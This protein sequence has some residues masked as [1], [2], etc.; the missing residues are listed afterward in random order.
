MKNIFEG[1]LFNKKEKE[2]P[3]PWYKQYEI[4]GVPAKLE[5][6]N[7][8]IFSFMEASALK[9]QKKVAYDF[10][11]YLTTYGELLDEI[12][13]C[14]KALKA[15]G[16]EEGDYVT[17]SMPNTPE[18]IIMFYAVN[19]VGAISNMIH[20]LAAPGEIKH[21]LSLVP[22]KFALIIDFNFETFNKIKKD[23]KLEKIITC[24]PSVSMP[25]LV[26]FG[27]WLTAGRKVPPIPQSDDVYDWYD[28]ISLSKNFEE[29]Y[30]CPRK[31]DDTAV[32]LYSGGTTGTSKGIELTNL[33]FN[34]IAMQSN[35][36]IDTTPGDSILGILPLFHCFGLAVCTHFVLS[37][38]VKTVLIPKFTPE[39]FGDLIKKKK[40]TFIVGVPALFEAMI[41]NPKLKNADLSFVK[42]MVSGGDSLS[43]ELKN[44]V[45]KFLHDRGSKAVITEG[46]GLTESCGPVTFSPRS[47]HIPGTIGIPFPDTIIKI[48]EVNTTKEVPLGLEGE[49]CISGLTLMKG[50]LNETEETK[51]TLRVHEDGKLWLHT[52]D[53]GRMDENGR[54]KFILRLKRIIVTNGYNVYPNAIESVLNSHKSVANSTVV[55]LP[56]QKRGQKVKAFIVLKKGVKASEEVK[57]S[58]KKLCESEIAKYS[59]PREYEFK[60]ALPRTLVGKVAFRELEKED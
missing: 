46:Y 31:G 41:N 47:N 57:T 2:Y 16:V 44:R 21:A 18:A 10:F 48:V 55:G 32:I 42:V 8:S 26:T 38:G 19:M 60:T 51:N 35:Q 29:S 7:Y 3:Y 17:I 13:E 12:H 1:K 14:A 20:P 4:D 45:D 30:I 58:I 50:Y 34:A 22:S 53:L 37:I 49:I 9:H 28:F 40:P 23:V 27:Y 39:T 56:C 15:L 54:I 36:M 33:N 52:G 5:Y 59:L 6:P 43:A 24:S 11:G 25:L